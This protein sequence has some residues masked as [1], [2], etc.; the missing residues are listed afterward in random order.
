MNARSTEGF[1]KRNV[2]V[3]VWLIWQ[4][5][6]DVSQKTKHKVLVRPNT[7]DVIIVGVTVANKGHHCCT[8]PSEC[9]VED[10]R[11]KVYN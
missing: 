5:R 7:D 9:S 8:G 3:C 11:Q 2:K 10:R 1:L 4:W 6:R